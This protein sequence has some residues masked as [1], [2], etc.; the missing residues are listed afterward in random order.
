MRRPASTARRRRRRCENAA[1]A[2]LEES[3]QFQFTGT[4]GAPGGAGSRPFLAGQAGSDRLDPR[5]EAQRHRFPRFVW[6]PR[7]PRPARRHRRMKFGEVTFRRP[8]V[9]LVTL[10]AKRVSTLSDR[11]VVSLA[12]LVD[13]AEQK[14]TLQVSAPAAFPLRITNS[15]LTPVH[16]AADDAGAASEVRGEFRYQPGAAAPEVA[17]LELSPLAAG[18]AS[19]AIV[20]LLRYDSKYDAARRFEHRA[21]LY[22]QSFGQ[23]RCRIV[24]DEPATIT[25]LRVNGVSRSEFAGREAT[26]TLDEEAQLLR[27]EVDFVTSDDA[28]G[29]LRMLELP[30]VRV[31]VPL[32]LAVRNVALPATFD[33]R[34]TPGY[35]R[36]A[37]TP[38]FLACDD[39]SVARSGG[40]DVEPVV[41]A[42]LVNRH[43][44][45]SLS[46]TDAGSRHCRSGR[47]LRADRRCV[48]VVGPGRGDRR[49]DGAEL[50]PNSSTSCSVNL[51]RDPPCSVLTPC[52][53]PSPES[54]RTRTS[55]RRRPRPKETA[56]S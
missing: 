2:E 45:N 32:L 49:S 42:G 37:A 5:P 7:L 12:S 48:P 46:T 50:G 44:G 52:R 41:A 1:G 56:R 3:Y 17:A 47:R 25:A 31:D 34:L 51:R 21:T 55:P 15:S 16:S 53:S 38:T 4:A 13:A 24:V 22:M 6:P 11:T 54:R 19:P 23:G 43:G 40:A 28:S 9:G 39:C 27:V 14:G 20:W 35:D 33:V 18:Q 36:R 29:R 8:V 10:D 26:L 30:V